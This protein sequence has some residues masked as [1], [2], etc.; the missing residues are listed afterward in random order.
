[1]WVNVISELC[2]ALDNGGRSMN[3]AP[4]SYMLANHVQNYYMLV[5]RMNLPIVVIVNK[6]L[7]RWDETQM[8]DSDRKR[9]YVVVKENQQG[10]GHC[11]DAV[12]EPTEEMIVG[13]KRGMSKQTRQEPC[14]GGEGGDREQGDGWGKVS[15]VGEGA[16]VVKFDTTGL[17]GIIKRERAI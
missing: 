8:G 15:K 11:V 7:R 12:A 13:W 9:V 1:M 17:P 16:A 10:V 5:E 2:G 6:V 14:Y 3:A 4:W